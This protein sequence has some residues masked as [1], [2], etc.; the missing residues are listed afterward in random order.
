[1]D[2]FSQ[3]NNLSSLGLQ[4]NSM[5]QR[6]KEA[7]GEILIESLNQ[8]EEGY[9]VMIIENYLYNIF[10]KIHHHEVYHTREYLVGDPI[11]VDISLQMKNSEYYQVMD[12][13]EDLF[14]ILNALV[15]QPK[16]K[17]VKKAIDM[18]R[19]GL[20]AVFQRFKVQYIVQSDFRIYPVFS[21]EEDKEIE[22]ILNENNTVNGYVS[23][24]LKEFTNHPGLALGEIVKGLEEYIRNSY[25]MKEKT[26]GKLVG[27]FKKDGSKLN[28][29]ENASKS[30][31]TFLEDI[32][33]VRNRT[34]GAGH[35]GT[36]E[37]TSL[38]SKYYIIRSI[39]TIN[40]LT[41]KL[42]MI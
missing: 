5:T 20:N 12:Y 4:V 36:D 21:D 27:V 17:N 38:E 41:T 28:L 37:I 3:R 25:G 1:M 34:K 23:K 26:L 31:I 35:S 42:N 11:L 7:I 39:S 40:L 24:S 29:N 16:M 13:I 22:T 2:V 19:S 9:G 8:I 18:M 33:I 15:N 6:T 30:V 14:E 32:Y 10:K